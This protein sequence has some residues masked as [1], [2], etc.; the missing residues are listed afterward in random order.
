M[1]DLYMKNN[2]VLTF[3]EKEGVA[4]SIKKI[5]T[6][7]LLPLCLS[8]E[9]TAETFNDW[10]SKRKIP[11][12]REGYAEAKKEFSAMYGDKW[13]QYPNRLSLSDQYWVKYRMEE[14]RKINFFTHPYSHDIGDLF[15][16]P[17][18][19]SP[20]RIKTNS[21]DLTTNG[22]LKKRWK[23]NKDD[24]TS[25]LL[26]AGSRITHQEPLSEILVSVLLEQLNIVPF[27]RYDFCI[28]GV[29]MCSKCQNFITENTELVPASYIYNLTPRKENESIYTHL[30]KAC[31]KFEI[32]NAKEFVDAMI[33][34]DSVTGNIDRNLGNIGFIRDVDTLKLRT[35]PLFDFGAAYWS[36]G[37]IEERMNSKIFGDVEKKI[38]AQMK[39]RCNLEAALKSEGYK[40][41]I[42]A[43]PRIS[44]LK[45]KNLIKAI[46][47]RNQTLLIEHKFDLER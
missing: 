43:Y 32:E 15:F 4:V 44:V 27:V 35:A 22:V 38:F 23:Q 29:T 14:W 9:C 34:I 33:F 13:N 12:K 1:P 36:S 19:A 37:K 5:D 39:H 21:P 42:E 31:D 25:S 16:M 41:C 47:S 18:G 20:K 3:E 8:N 45:K 24:M 11:D 17:W 40:R 28:E 2:K 10:M 7:E 30:L 46:S 26:K 6:P